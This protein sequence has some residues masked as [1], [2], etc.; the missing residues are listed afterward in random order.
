MTLAVGATFKPRVKEYRI[1]ICRDKMN[2][3]LSVSQNMSQNMTISSVIFHVIYIDN[4][5][6]VWFSM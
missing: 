6:D 4:R 3:H 1:S 2:V 5:C